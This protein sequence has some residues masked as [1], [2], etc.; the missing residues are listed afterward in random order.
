MSRVCSERKHMLKDLIFKNRSYRRFDE[1]A[2]ISLDTL[3][4]LVDLARHSASGANQQPLKFFLSADRETNGK[5]F[6]SLAW[7]GALKDWEGP[8]AGER[9][10]AYIIILGD[11]DISNGFGVNHGI[12]AQSILLGAVEKGFGGCMLGAIKRG[13]IRRDLNIDKKYEVLLVI[14]L[15]R[16][17][18][19]VVVE[20]IPE[21]GKTAYWR[22]EDGVHHVPKRSLEDLII[23]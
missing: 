23:N 5:I 16:P 4:E 20:D 15:G 12:A 3:V 14:A 1:S 19:K 6:P 18:E 21:D 13:E 10:S 11:T 17:A 9:P 7:A 22:D 2:E 8:E